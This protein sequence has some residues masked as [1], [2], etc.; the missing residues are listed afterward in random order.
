MQ[1]I[2][3]YRNP[4]EAAFWNAFMSSG[5]AFLILAV[6]I[7]GLLTSIADSVMQSFIKKHRHSFLSQRHS[8]IAGFLVK[9]KT[10]ICLAIFFSTFGSFFYLLF[11]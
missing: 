10:A 3:V 2:I 6:I 7:S 5:G 4:L 1:E 9:Y 8:A 11:G